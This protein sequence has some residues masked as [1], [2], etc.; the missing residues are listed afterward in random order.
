MRDEEVELLK[1]ALITEMYLEAADLD[2]DL[3]SCC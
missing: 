2:R 3:S 1:T